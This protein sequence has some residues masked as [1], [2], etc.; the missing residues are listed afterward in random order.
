MTYIHAVGIHN[1][2]PAGELPDLKA[3]LKAL[4]GK[5]Y[6]RIDHFIQL[7]IIGAHKG[8]HGHKLSPDTA[9]YM[10]SGQGNI[11]VFD[12]VRDQ[13][14]I[15]KLLP[16]PVDFINLLSN[17]AGF[18]VAT[19]LGLEGKNLFLAHQSFPV[20]M[21]MLV[22][23]NDLKLGKQKCVL[24]GGVDEW[25]VKQELSKKLL[26][27]E[28]TMVLGEGSNWLL[29]DTNAE[30][31]LGSFDMEP[32]ALD[33]QQLQQFLSSAEVGTKL[34]FSRRICDDEA[35][36][37]MD[38][39]RSCQRFDYETSSGYYETLPLYALNSFLAGK[40]KGR[41]IHIDVYKGRYMVMSVENFG[42]SP[43]KA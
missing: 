42:V 20:Q 23:Q 37:I 30:G 21:T 38:M 29:I 14:Y 11:A 3:E 16:K 17:S 12:R 15:H 27:V 24:V 8:L 36:G 9:I 4:S 10:T 41:L 22:A 40:E 39:N 13:R 2:I 1:T 18:Y 28:D 7:A 31:A 33:K 26:G 32:K 35:D 25:V 6:R 19:H 34:A 43:S 5:V